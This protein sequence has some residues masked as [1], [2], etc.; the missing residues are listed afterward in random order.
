MF[1]FVG[2]CHGKCASQPNQASILI[3]DQ[4]CGDYLFRT[5]RD[6]YANKTALIIDSNNGRLRVGYVVRT[7]AKLDGDPSLSTLDPRRRAIRVKDLHAY[8]AIV[9]ATAAAPSATP[10]PS[11]ATP[12]SP[13]STRTTPAPRTL[14]APSSASTSPCP[15]PSASTSCGRLGRTTTPT[16]RRASSTATGTSV[17]LVQKGSET[18]SEL[19]MDSRPGVGWQ[20]DTREGG[21]WLPATA[22]R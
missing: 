8:A 20:R 3:T 2:R 4:L 9:V 21:T 17:D 11:C 1:S 18:W 7:T 22:G 16:K 15:S 5:T 10:P 13:P 6:R 14:P 12:S 19:G